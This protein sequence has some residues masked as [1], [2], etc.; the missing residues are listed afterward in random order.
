MHRSSQVFVD[1][2]L[3]RDERVGADDKELAARLRELR[4]ERD[5]A[6]KR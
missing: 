5:K 6:T 2:I 4:S 1:A 3:G